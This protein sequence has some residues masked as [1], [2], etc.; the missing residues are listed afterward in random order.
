MKAAR[1]LAIMFSKATKVDSNKG[2]N[3]VL[4]TITGI[5]SSNR[6]DVK[7]KQALLLA[8]GEMLYSVS[9]QVIKYMKNLI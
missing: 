1:I 9:S 5:I 8:L 6:N 2:L 3:E 7:F 4:Q